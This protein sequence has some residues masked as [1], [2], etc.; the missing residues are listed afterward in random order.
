MAKGAGGTEGG[1]GQFF[2]GL[3]MMCG[4][5]YL[6]LQSI[7][8]STNF[9]MGL[10]MFRIPVYGLNYFNVPGGIIFIPFMFGIGMIFYDSKKILGWILACGSMAALIIGVISNTNLQM[11]T[12][13]AFEL[14]LIIVLFVGGIGMFL[15]SLRNLEAENKNKNVL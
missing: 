2:M 13:T 6:L 9:H 7:T 3:L 14:V 15:N 5:G 10:N 11:K 12:M 4:G 1:T 8:I